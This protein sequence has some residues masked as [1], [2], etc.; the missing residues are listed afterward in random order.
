MKKVLM[1]QNRKSSPLV[2][3]I[4]TSEKENQAYLALFKYLDESWQVYSDLI[5]LSEP[6]KPS[7][8]L[9]VITGL[10][11]G[12]LKDQAK[13]EHY[14]YENAVKELKT[15][16]YQAKLYTSAKKGEVIGAKKLITLRR[17]YEYEQYDILN[18][19]NS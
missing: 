18:I 6:K 9:E 15:K 4:S 12:S 3:D 19:Q 2:W 10:P 8:S 13:R 16:Q 14:E 5:D 11:D 17:Y 7:L 1:Y